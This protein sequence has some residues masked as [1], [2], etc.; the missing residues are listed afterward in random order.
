[1]NGIM[2]GR[3]NLIISGG[4]S[5]SFN[6]S[7]DLSIL[8]RYKKVDDFTRRS[9]LRIYYFSPPTL[10]LGFFQKD[11]NKDR[12]KKAQ[13]T[14]ESVIERAKSKGYDIVSRPTGGRAVLHK[15][16]ITY[17]I[18]SSYKTGIFAGKL[19]E[20]YNKVSE[21]LKLFFINLGLKPDDNFSSGAAADNT[22]N[23][24]SGLLLK[25]NNFNCFLKTHSYEIT[26]GGKKICGNSQRRSDTAFLQ[27]GSIYID[28]NPLEHIELFE[29]GDFNGNSEYFKNITGIKQ[30]MKKAGVAF[31]LNY[32]EFDNLSK[33][34][35]DSF[36]NAYNLDPEPADLT[37]AG[38]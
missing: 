38:I 22:K 17:S 16:E 36:G 20:T 12:D 10:S 30:E 4:C 14:S 27:H 24:S 11:K 19:L 13:D 25:K 18:T 8:D 35:A 3:F 15:S 9:T 33:I 34:M 1:M 7:A 23:N 32:L 37:I 2:D 29:G 28:Y 6:M 31:D 21:F 5:G 26:F